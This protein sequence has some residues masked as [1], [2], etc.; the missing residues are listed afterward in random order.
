MTDEQLKKLVEAYVENKRELDSYTKLCKEEGDAIKSGMFDLD[1]TEVPVDAKKALKKIISVKFEVDE[2]KML[3]V[4]KKYNVPAV[5]TVEVID[6]GALENFL[7]HA[8]EEEN[9]DLLNELDGCKTI[10]S[11]VSLKLV[12]RKIE[13]D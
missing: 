2:A 10:K 13:E 8:D 3:A 12:N 1:I 7:Y 6:E 5:K 4:L 11:V 9:R